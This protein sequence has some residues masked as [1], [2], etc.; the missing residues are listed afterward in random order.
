MYTTATLLSTYAY[1]MYINDI[2][3]ENG[4]DH[5]FHE[6]HDIDKCLKLR[7]TDFVLSSLQILE[8]GN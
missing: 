1:I 8:C 5:E 3:T 6:R 2:S 7:V 4:N